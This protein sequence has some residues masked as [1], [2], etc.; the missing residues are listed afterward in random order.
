MRLLHRRL[1]VLVMHLRLPDIMLRLRVITALRLLP[2]QDNTLVQ[3]MTEARAGII[4]RRLAVR[5]PVQ[6]PRKVMI[7]TIIAAPDVKEVITK[8]IKIEL[9]AATKGSGRYGGSDLLG[10][11]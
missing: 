6:D 4:G 9:S 2:R 1:R 7:G 3:N 11:F 10:L 8:T 5:M